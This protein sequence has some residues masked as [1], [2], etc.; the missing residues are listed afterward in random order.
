MCVFKLSFNLKPLAFLFFKP[1][2]SPRPRHVCLGVGILGSPLFSHPAFHLAAWVPSCLDASSPPPISKPSGRC[3]VQATP[4]SLLRSWSEP[5]GLPTLLSLN[6]LC[7]LGPSCLLRE[8][9]KVLDQR[10]GDRCIPDSSWACSVRRQGAP[11]HA[12][13]SEEQQV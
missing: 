1:P 2:P 4:Q 7:V 10:P 12:D 3:E 6:P 8:A 11:G 5:S 9:I 13:P